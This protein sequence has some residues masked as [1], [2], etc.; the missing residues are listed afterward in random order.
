[1][2]G[3]ICK[4]HFHRT[5]DLE[6]QPHLSRV[7]HLG[8]V[9]A[10]VSRIPEVGHACAPHDAKSQLGTILN[11]FVVVTA[12]E[13]PTTVVGAW[14]RNRALAQSSSLQILASPLLF[15]LLAAASALMSAPPHV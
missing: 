4:V 10:S 15:S 6:M 7:R 2:N 11:T 3:L 14:R 5:Q 13:E 1:M 9:I 8:P 12:P